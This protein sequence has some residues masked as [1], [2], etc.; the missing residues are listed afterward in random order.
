MNTLR[1]QSLRHVSLRALFP[2]TPHARALSTWCDLDL[3]KSPVLI[4]RETSPHFNLSVEDWCGHSPYVTQLFL[5]DSYSA[6]VCN[7][8]LK[9]VPTDQPALFV[10]RNTPCV[11]IGRNQVHIVSPYYDIF[12]ASLIR[13][14]ML[15]NP[16]KEVNLGALNALNIQLVRRRSGGG[17]V[18][19]VRPHL[20]LPIPPHHPT[21]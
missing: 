10:Y 17:T 2:R 21:N 5:S 20:P 11:V 9:N 6:P 3:Q 8:L 7:R 15:Q 19:H 13:P 16:W 4:S 14:F 18:F 12:C 1:V